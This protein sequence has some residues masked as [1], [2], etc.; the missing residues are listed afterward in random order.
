MLQIIIFQLSAMIW[1]TSSL[2]KGTSIQV[3]GLILAA[4]FAALGLAQG[5]AMPALAPY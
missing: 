1:M 3:I 2:A 5:A 4:L